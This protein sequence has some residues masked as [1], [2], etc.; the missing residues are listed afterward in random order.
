MAAVEHSVPLPSGARA[1]ATKAGV[2]VRSQ[3]NELICVLTWRQI[4]HLRALA[5]DQR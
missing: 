3:A 5:L 2:E 1:V 4:D